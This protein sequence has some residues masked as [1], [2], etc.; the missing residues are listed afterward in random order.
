MNANSGGKM[1]AADIRV[2]GSSLQVGVPHELFDSGY[3][4]FPHSGTYHAYAVS[5]DGQRFLIPRPTAA[6]TDTA[7][8]PLTVV[9]N[10]TAALTKK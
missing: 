9:V 7:A 8:T 3:T 6:T 10:W 5:A 2:S 4:N 1:M